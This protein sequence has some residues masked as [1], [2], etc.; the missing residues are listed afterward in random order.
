MMLELREGSCLPKALVRLNVGLACVDGLIAILAFYQ[1]MRIHSRNAQLGWTR[2]KVFHL[3]I[4]SSNLG[5]FLYFLL[6]LVA[7]CKGWLCWSHSC[8]FI[9]VACPEILFVAA[10]LLLLSF[11]VDLCHQS[12]DEDDDEEGFSPRDALLEKMNKT[13]R[14]VD[15]RRKCCSFRAIHAGSRQ[16]VVI[17]V[18]M[19]VFALMIAFAVLIWIGLGRNPIDS[20][21]VAQVYVDIFSIAVLL[22]GGALASYGLILFLKMRKVRSEMASSEMWKVAGLTIV[23][24]ICFTASACVSISTNVPLLYHWHQ[25]EINGVYAAFLL[26]L[27]YFLGSSVPSAFVLWVMRELPPPVITN[28]QQESRTIAFISDSMVTVHPLCWAADT[29]VQNQATREIPV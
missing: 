26:V 27:Y 17:L 28:R 21:T 20:A 16:K 15:G 3:L 2:Q 1:L 12:N 24:V 9:V 11:W 18:T 29:S 13:D 19:I 6:T 7:A 10:F 8:G 25:Q 22:L 23:C 14:N 4:G 5:Y